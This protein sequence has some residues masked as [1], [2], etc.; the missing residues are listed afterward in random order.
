MKIAFLDLNFTFR[1]TTRAIINYTKS[2]KQY[3]EHE[4]VIIVLARK[5]KICSE[6]VL[7]SIKGDYLDI[8][9]YLAGELMREVNENYDCVYHVSGGES[10]EENHI[11]HSLKYH[12]IA[13]S[14]L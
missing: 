3:T 4:A 6:L 14:W 8:R 10:D 13:S 11:L 7:E 1:G 12:F 9:V 2:I 5:K